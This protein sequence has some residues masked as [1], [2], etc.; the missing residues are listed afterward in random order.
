[1]TISVKQITKRA[2]QLRK[3]HKLSR[4]AFELRLRVPKATIKN[5]E[6]GYR[7]LALAYLLTIRKVYGED[8]FQ[9]IMGVTKTKPTAPH[10]K[11]T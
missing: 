5:Y 1:M 8:W 6:L 4:S 3:D 10:I 7:P 9:W 11:L 2:M